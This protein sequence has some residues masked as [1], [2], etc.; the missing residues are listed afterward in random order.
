[1]DAWTSLL[2]R[3]RKHIGAEYSAR[4]YLYGGRIDMDFN[5]VLMFGVVACFAL[6]LMNGGI[7]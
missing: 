3:I 1:M 4:K 7:R 6:N 2:G 5:M